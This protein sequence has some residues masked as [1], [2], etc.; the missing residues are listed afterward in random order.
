VSRAVIRDG[1]A[2]S[3]RSQAPVPDQRRKNRANKLR[4]VP[5]TSAGYCGPTR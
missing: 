4:M 1:P 5:T 3:S 2:T